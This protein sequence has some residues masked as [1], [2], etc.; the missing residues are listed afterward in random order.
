L[1]DSE[2][3]KPKGNI[4]VAGENS[5]NFVRWTQDG[6]NL[7]CASRRKI[8]VID[9]NSGTEREVHDAGLPIDAMETMRVDG[10]D[11]VYAALNDHQAAKYSL[12]VLKLGVM[13]SPVNF[14][15]SDPCGA[16]AV[17]A[18]TGRIAYAI[19]SMEDSA[20]IEAGGNQRNFI[21]YCDGALNELCR[22][23]HGP[24]GSG[25]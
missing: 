9:A 23:D 4:K 17:C 1:Y 5:I 11:T 18:Q 7:I 15:L 13:Q 6:K 12:S 8:H 21:V 20:F 16:I 10:V 25:Q 19:N 3:L 22:V 24:A 2:Y 14:V